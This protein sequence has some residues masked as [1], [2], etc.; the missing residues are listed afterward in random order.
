MARTKQTARKSHGGKV[1]IS[2]CVGSGGACRK[3]A[4]VTGFVKSDHDSSDESVS[5]EEQNRTAELA[6]TGGQDSS[7]RLDSTGQPNTTGADQPDTMDLT[8]SNDNESAPKRLRRLSTELNQIDSTDDVKTLEDND[9]QLVLS[10]NIEMLFKPDDIKVSIADNFLEVS[11]N[12]EEKTE[13]WSVKRQ[14]SGKYLLPEPEPC[15]RSLIQEKMS[16]SLSSLGVLKVTIPKNP[17][18]VID[19]TSDELP[20]EKPDAGH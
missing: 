16:Y 20:I 9:K 10:F 4:P 3:S 2:R 12:R 6:A 11:A 13:L 17:K 14:Y 7:D 8:D 5:S 1:P 19:L 15:C 18:A